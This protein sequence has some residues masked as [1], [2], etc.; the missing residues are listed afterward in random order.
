MVKSMDPKTGPAVVLV[1]CGPCA[2]TMKTR[3]SMH[4]FLQDTYC[5]VPSMIL[6]NSIVPLEYDE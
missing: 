3:N 6:V 4:G 5:D 2:V 1:K